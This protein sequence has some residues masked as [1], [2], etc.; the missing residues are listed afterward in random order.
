ME[1]DLND[2]DRY[3]MEMSFLAFFD[4]FLNS[5]N[6]AMSLDMSKIGKEVMFQIAVV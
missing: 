1:A 6:S 2:L 4:K 3:R 5:F